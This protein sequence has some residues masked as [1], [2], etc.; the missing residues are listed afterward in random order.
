MPLIIMPKFLAKWTRSAHHNEQDQPIIRRCYA[1]QRSTVCKERQS[2]SLI[3]RRSRSLCLA[4]VFEDSTSEM[5][6][7]VRALWASVS[8]ICWLAQKYQTK[9]KRITS[10]SLEGVVDFENTLIFS[11]W[12]LHKWVRTIYQALQL[13]V[14]SD[15]L[16]QLW[17]AWLIQRV[18]F[19]HLDPM[20]HTLQSFPWWVG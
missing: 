16:A 2:R 12:Q 18:S 4:L 8:A 6:E 1:R 3:S 7:K 13:V 9:R 5:F 19:S 10:T 11:L 15:H 20:I 14:G 17:F